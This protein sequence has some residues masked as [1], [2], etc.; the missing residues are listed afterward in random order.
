L[1]VEELDRYLSGVGR[2]ALVL[3]GHGHDYLV[4]ALILDLELRYR[5]VSPDDL[6]TPQRLTFWI[7]S[8]SMVRAVAK[9]L[10]AAKSASNQI[11]TDLLRM[12]ESL[13]LAPPPLAHP[14]S[15]TIG[16]VSARAWYMA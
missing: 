10:E 13:L 11:G 6:S 5:E 16:R 14:F 4:G 15:P 12:V 7:G 2:S 9:A 8:D 1:G 3:E